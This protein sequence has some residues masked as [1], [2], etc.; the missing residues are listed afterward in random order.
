[1][2]AHVVLFRP[3]STLTDE[4]RAAFFTAMEQAFANI[5]AIKRA[6]VGRRQTL[7]RFYDQQN[8]VDFP[9]AAILEFESESDLREYLDHP[10][11]RS[12][13]E[14]FYLTSDASLVFD[15]VL[16][17]SDRARDLLA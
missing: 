17:D 9:F 1:V 5:A 10:A 12:L 16:V 13:G 14:Q 7:G 8:G 2:I 11:H 15:F 6:R 3:K 4:E